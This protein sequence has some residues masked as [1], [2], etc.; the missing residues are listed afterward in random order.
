MC[1]YRTIPLSKSEIARFIH[2]FIMQGVLDQSLLLK[3]VSS[4]RKTRKSYRFI[5]GADNP[6]PRNVFVRFRCVPH[7]NR[8]RTLLRNHHY[9]QANLAYDNF[10]IF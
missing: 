8:N 5:F 3:I 9:Q 10:V 7:D 6:K 1:E 4:T 2:H